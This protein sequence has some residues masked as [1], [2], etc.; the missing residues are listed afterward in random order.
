MVDVLLA[1]FDVPNEPDVLLDGF[2]VLEVLL[3]RLAVVV[4]VLPEEPD[5]LD[6]V[7]LDRLFFAGS[8]G[9][10]LLADWLE[11][12]LLTDWLEE[13]LLADWLDEVLFTGSLPEITRGR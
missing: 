8:L 6:E 10:V 1:G 11:R 7:L 3:D 12:V 4:D 2:A 13:V 5:A 9:R